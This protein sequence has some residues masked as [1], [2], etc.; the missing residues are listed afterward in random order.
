LEIPFS[1]LVFSHHRLA[2]VP[3]AVAYLFL[4]RSM[5]AHDQFLVAALI[6]S[7]GIVTL[8]VCLPLIYRKVP[9]N[10]FYGI[11]IPQSF[12]SVERWYDINAYGGRLLARWSCLIVITGV[13]GFLVPLPFLQAYAITA[14]GVILI[15]VFAPLIQVIRWAR[16]TRQT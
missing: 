14:A 2:S 8:C 5:T 11:R 16:A 1:L 15:S 4:V 7:A 6:L 3:V 10:R 13:V 12:V 9:M